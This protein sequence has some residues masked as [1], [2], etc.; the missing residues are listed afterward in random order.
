[1]AS[2]PPPTGGQESIR[3]QPHYEDTHETLHDASGLMGGPL[4]KGSNT[5]N[6]QD[7]P[8]PSSLEPYP[9]ALYCIV[10]PYATLWLFFALQISPSLIRWFL[11]KFPEVLYITPFSI[12]VLINSVMLFVIESFIVLASL[13]GNVY[14]LFWT[15]KMLR[16][17]PPFLQKQT[18]WSKVRQAS[19]VLWFAIGD[20]LWAV[21]GRYIPFARIWSSLRT[22]SNRL[23][24]TTDESNTS[25]IWR[26]L[27]SI[28]AVTFF[29]MYFYAWLQCQIDM[30]TRVEKFSNALPRLRSGKPPSDPDNTE[31]TYF[32]AYMLFILCA[33]LWFQYILLLGL[34]YLSIPIA[35][36]LGLVGEW[37][38]SLS[39]PV[40]SS[41]SKFI[42]WVCL[43]RD[44]FAL[45]ITKDLV[46]V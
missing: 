13:F 33:T 15:M 8:R 40:L 32:V 22:L 1:M 27:R 45:K 28:V 24:R 7:I 19:R 17:S 42:T 5:T 4:K 37:A 14:G 25:P 34:V 21:G 9:I 6:G 26:R 10:V 2:L 41:F 30:V 46:A 16:F 20:I 29:M 38:E 31:D 36:R 43:P 35:W 11:V 12:S 39:E 18:E 3:E 44:H 23:R